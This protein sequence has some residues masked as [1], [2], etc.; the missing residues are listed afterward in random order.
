MRRTAIGLMALLLLATGLI[1]QTA[2][3]TLND[4]PP[5]ARKV[6]DGLLAGRTEALNGLSSEAFHPQAFERRSRDAVA[7]AQVGL[8]TEMYKTG[9]VKLVEEVRV[10]DSSLPE[11]MIFRNPRGIAVDAQG[12]VY[13]A[14]SGAEHLKIFGPDGKFIRA[15]GRKGQ[16]PGE[17]QGPEFVEIG[18]GRIFVW[19]S[20]NRRISIFD[21]EGKFLSSAASA[22]F[23]TG[24]FGVFI[25]MRALPDGRLIVHYERG[26]TEGAGDRPADSQT[27]I[28]GLL[29][30][31]GKPV[32]TL[33]EK[34]VR[35]CRMV[36]NA[37]YNANV[38]VPFPYHPT[39]HMEV[40]T[41]GDLAA[42]G[43]EKY[44]IE[45]YNP[46]KGRL[47]SFV[48]PYTPIP[49]SDRDK[50]DHFGRF[51]MAVFKDG[52]KTMIPKPPDVILEN[53]EFPEKLPPYRDLIADGEGHIWVQLYAENRAM[54][55]FDVFDP[56]EGFIS[57]MT[58]EGAPIDHSFAGS[59]S[60]RFSGQVL[61]RIEQDEEG[62]SS[63]V[64]Y[65]LTA[66]RT[67]R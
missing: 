50:Q 57:R 22:P 47:T 54:N 29:S 39:L 6:F 12:R 63:L 4:L 56:Q 24:A 27:Q 51:R 1:G 46:D 48:R 61:W 38:R 9:S 28:I 10:S 65:R 2:G 49:L 17:F 64:R 33:L 45:I 44:E 67:S 14:D 53:T 26:L 66:G 52:M 11:D 35:S 18:G 32:R 25:Q 3:K 62:Y 20:M 59:L 40:T 16:G 55:V 41:A 5:A 23:F 15:I 42:G 37:G 36:W 43:S 58:L 60:N 8:L 34:K 30:A 21:A 7:A 31:D 13:V 19:E